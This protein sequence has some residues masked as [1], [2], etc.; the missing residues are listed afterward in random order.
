MTLISLR[1]RN[2][3]GIAHLVRGLAYS[4]LGQSSDAELD[5]NSAAAFSE[6]EMESFKNVFGV[7]DS[8]FKNTK[9][10]LSE[11][12]TELLVLVTNQVNITA[13]IGISQARGNW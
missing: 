7:I 10:M 3:L 1:G 8:P 13:L 6:S 2:G 5:F 9:A 4:A 11:E 12:T